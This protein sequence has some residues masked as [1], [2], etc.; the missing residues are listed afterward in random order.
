MDGNLEK[1]GHY[2]IV[3]K[4][5][6][7]GMG[8]VYLAQDTK[9]NREVAL[10]VLPEQRA[11]DPERL[12]RFQRE[13][14]AIAALTHPNIVTIHSVEEDAGSHFITMEL[15]RGETL[16]ARIPASGMTLD[17]VFEIAIPLL[18]AITAAHESGITHRDLKPDNIMISQNGHVKVLDFGLAKLVQE[19][20][21]DP[22]QTMTIDDG[23]TKEGRILGT[24]AYMSPEQAEGKAI[25]HRSDIFSLGVILY[26][27]VTGKSPFKGDSHVSTLSAVLRDDPTSISELK[28]NLPTH[29]GR[30]ISRCLA[31]DPRERYQTA[32]D[33]KNELKLLKKESASSL[34]LSEASSQARSEGKSKKPLV[35]VLLALG[36]LALV[37]GIFQTQNRSGSDQPVGDVA[38]TDRRA[39]AGSGATDTQESSEQSLA[40]LAFVNMS[41]DPENEY[42]SDGI[43]E[44]ILNSLS[45]LSGLKV[46][47][48]TSAFSMKGKGLDI[49]TIAE[50]L[51]V[52]H[53]LEG[54]VRRAGNRVR[55]TAKLIDAKTE[56]N[57]WSESY[58]REMKDVFAVQDEIAKHI[59]EALEVT[60]GGDAD[61]SVVK[62]ETVPEAYDLYLQA[63]YLLNLRGGENLR[64]A[65]DLFLQAVAI[66]ENFAEAWSGLS[67]VW[68]V[69]AAYTK[70][71]LEESSRKVRKYS[72][73]ALA[74]DSTLLEPLLVQ[75]SNHSLTL[76][77]EQVIPAYESFLELDPNNAVAL[78]W[79]AEELVRMGY[80]DRAERLLRKGYDADPLLGPLAM[81]LG[82]L[83]ARKGDFEGAQ[84][85][86]QAAVDAGFRWGEYATMIAALVAKDFVAA[87][88][89]GVPLVPL[90]MS[91]TEGEIRTVFR[92]ATDNSKRAEGLETLDRLARELQAGEMTGADCPIVIEMFFQY[93]ELDRLYDFVLSFSE[94]E[95]ALLEPVFWGVNRGELRKDPR[96]QEFVKQRKLLDL[97]QKTGNWPDGCG[98]SGDGIACD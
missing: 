97:W 20:T 73:R 60:L 77:W 2:R 41:G 91:V 78:L 90:R 63:R 92:G 21:V 18:D 32:L 39:T 95:N 96:F 50:R 4:I 40:V 47:S 94:E 33:V 44:E 75:S 14:Q 83:L 52:E 22:N 79:F 71:D 54:S 38:G 85:F 16:G 72:D 34:D 28:S 69:M 30:V 82:M 19:A 58:D 15:V 26:E 23:Q 17:G 49:P 98:P 42:F 74:L 31:K 35:G 89:A 27:M 9:L 46:S 6:S 65:N 48:R 55:I 88:R 3:D 36:L 51:K 53:V 62:I 67:V 66:D 45:K 93:G 8:D 86:G 70:V 7:G 43:S 84:E 76:D 10:K 37:F 80:L 87:E 12:A 64:K 81:N 5:G 1:L 11:S 25:D 57:L 29:L 68:N 24:A 61:N 13:A 56:S 59:V